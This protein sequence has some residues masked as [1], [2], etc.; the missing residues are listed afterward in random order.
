MTAEQAPGGGSH[1]GVEER[2]P[3]SHVAG[4]VADVHGHRLRGV[5]EDPQL[6]VDLEAPGLAVG[7][8]GGQARSVNDGASVVGGQLP[9]GRAVRQVLGGRR[10]ELR[11]LDLGQRLI[12]VH[13]DAARAQRLATAQAADRGGHRG[14]TER[15]V[16]TELRPGRQGEPDLGQGGGTP[17]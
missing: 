6:I 9:I 2:G 15:D 7:A 17:S 5:E 3:E 13:P 10:L 11:G 4:P 12:K 14:G 8:R 16:T 1:P